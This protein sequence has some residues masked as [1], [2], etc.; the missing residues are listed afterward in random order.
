MK[1]VAV[2]GAL[3]LGGFAVVGCEEKPATPANKPATTT[4]APASTTT[5]PA[6]KANG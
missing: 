4:P 6:P 5:T 1:K 3:V 2:I